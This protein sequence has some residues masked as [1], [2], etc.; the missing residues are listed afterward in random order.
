MGL[1]Q[2]MFSGMTVFAI[3]KSREIPENR[4]TKGLR[5]VY[6]CTSLCKVSTKDLGSQ[7][8][9]GAFGGYTVRCL[10]TAVTT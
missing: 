5:E 9:S 3:R 6:F 4:E 10:L 2:A 1:G 8:P 7:G